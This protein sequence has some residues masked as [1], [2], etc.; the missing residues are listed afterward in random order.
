[1]SGFT[2]PHGCSSPDGTQGPREITAQG[3]VWPNGFNAHA[4]RA[5]TEADV[6]LA[7]H[8]EGNPV[9]SPTPYKSNDIFRKI[10]VRV[11]A[12]PTFFSHG[13]RTEDNRAF[14]YTRGRLKID[15][16]GLIPYSASYPKFKADSCATSLRVNIAIANYCTKAKSVN[17]NA[18]S[19]I[20]IGQLTEK[21]NDP[22]VVSVGFWPHVM[23]KRDMENNPL[24]AAC[25]D[26][27][28]LVVSPS[29]EA[30]DEYLPIRGYWPANSD[31]DDD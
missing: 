13:E 1:M 26:G 8:I 31:G 5:D 16:D 28:G 12:I 29:A 24:G 6:I 11:G 20:W 3:I 15:L 22:D 21:F 4:V 17:K 18:R 25:G 7:D 9:M 10:K 2:I 27:Y 30:I 14:H 19:D 23:V